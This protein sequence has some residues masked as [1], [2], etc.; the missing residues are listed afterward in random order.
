MRRSAFRVAFPFERQA[1]SMRHSST[2]GCVLLYKAFLHQGELLSRAKR[3]VP[4]FEC[5][6]PPQHRIVSSE[7]L[8]PHGVRVARPGAAAMLYDCMYSDSVGNRCPSFGLP[9]HMVKARN[10]CVGCCLAEQITLWE[11]HRD[12]SERYCSSD[13]D[14]NASTANEARM[15]EKC[16][17]RFNTHLQ[18]NPSEKRR[19]LVAAFKIATDQDRE[20][21]AAKACVHNAYAY[22]ARL[23]SI[24]RTRSLPHARATVEV[25]SSSVC[26]E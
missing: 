5:A 25:C 18:T 10:M 3:H 24:K 15:I 14:I 9:K 2:D 23:A 1:V 12:R 17:K 22:D 21:G 26:H 8:H 6:S 13:A 16:T 11:R 20:P 19:R 7:L 4:R